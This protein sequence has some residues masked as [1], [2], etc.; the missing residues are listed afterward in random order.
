MKGK[1]MEVEDGKLVREG[2]L[3]FAKEYLHV[4]ACGALCYGTLFVMLVLS[5]YAKK[6]A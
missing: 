2:A 4:I 3:H 1:K 6:F 5:A